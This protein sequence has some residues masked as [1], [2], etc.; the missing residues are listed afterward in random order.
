[1]HHKR[2]TLKTAGNEIPNAE[3]RSYDEG[4]EGGGGAGGLGKGNF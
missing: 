3:C 1:M 4:V 2:D